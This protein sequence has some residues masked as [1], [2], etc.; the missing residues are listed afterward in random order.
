MTINSCKKQF[1]IIYLRYLKSAITK[2]LFADLFAFEQLF[3]DSFGFPFVFLSGNI[4]LIATIKV[5][6]IELLIG[7]IED[8]QSVDK[9]PL[10]IL[11]LF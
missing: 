11:F 3:A 2:Q 5:L 10:S 9:N 1:C 8:R 4:L 7:L 6:Y